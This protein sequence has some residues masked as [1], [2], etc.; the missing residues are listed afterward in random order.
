MR[1]LRLQQ[2][3]VRPGHHRNRRIRT[4]HLRRH[5]RPVVSPPHLDVLVDSLVANQV[6]VLVVVVVLGV[7]LAQVVEAVVAAAWCPQLASY[8]AKL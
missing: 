2:M 8:R 7:A 4:R 5:G 1:C 6:E 3:E